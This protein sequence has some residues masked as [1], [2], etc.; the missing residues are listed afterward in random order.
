VLSP[1][2]LVADLLELSPLIALLLI[3]LRVDCIGCPLNKFCT[4]E[5]L[6]RHYELHLENTSQR[7][8][9]KISKGIRDKS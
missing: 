3:E 4:L 5:D 7:I 6:C 1:R 2:I 8:R 9:D